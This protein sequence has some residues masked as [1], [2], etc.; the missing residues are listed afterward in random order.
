MDIHIKRSGKWLKNGMIAYNYATFCAH[1]P[2]L[3]L[4]RLFFKDINFLSDVG[5]CWILDAKL[6]DSERSNFRGIIFR[7]IKCSWSLQGFFWNLGKVTMLSTSTCNCSSLPDISLIQQ[8]LTISLPA[9]KF[10]GKNYE[11]FS[12]GNYATILQIGK[13]EIH[14]SLQRLKKIVF[15]GSDGAE[16]RFLYKRKHDLQDTH[17]I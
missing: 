14:A 4:W 12:A 1:I 13:V 16:H 2:I 8:A 3:A 7:S 9:D 11:T 6:C 5:N 10:S 15:P 17:I